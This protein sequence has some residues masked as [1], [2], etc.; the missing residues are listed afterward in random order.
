MWDHYWS[1]LSGC[2]ALIPNEYK[3]R[4][5]RVGQHLRCKISN[6]Y[7]LRTAG[8]SHEHHS[9]P[10]V[11]GGIAT[12]LWNSVFNTDKTIKAN[13][14]HIIVKDRKES[15]SLLMLLVFWLIKMLL[16]MNLINHQFYKLSKY[17]Y[18]EITIQNPNPIWKLQQSLRNE[19]R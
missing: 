16:S 12:I 10:V 19:L 5:D 9:D 18:L 1:S 2:S 6:W 3:V 7:G 13:R 17:K 15:T 14:Q 4:H 11:E 8:N